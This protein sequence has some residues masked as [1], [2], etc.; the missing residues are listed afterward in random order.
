MSDSTPPFQTTSIVTVPNPEPKRPPGCRSGI[1][2][3]LF[4]CIVANSEI[5]VS[6]F[7][8]PREGVAEVDGEVQMVLESVEETRAL[9]A[10][11]AAV[12]K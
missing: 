3:A 10:G 6:A 11:L 9:G 4:L 8:R 12:V 7:S 1:P 2:L 5:K